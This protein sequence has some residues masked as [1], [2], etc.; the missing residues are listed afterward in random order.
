MISKTRIMT[1]RREGHKQRWQKLRGGGEMSV[2]AAV[3]EVWEVRNFTWA[4]VTFNGIYN[5]REVGHRMGVGSPRHEARGLFN[6]QPLSQ[7]STI[8]YGMYSG[9][10]IGV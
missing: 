2:T 7:T 1:W 10:F 5:A 9:I 8:C 4:W 3:R 6:I